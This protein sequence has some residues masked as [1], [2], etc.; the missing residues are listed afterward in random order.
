[1]SLG[2]TRRDASAIDE[3]RGEH[4]RTHSLRGLRA[5]LHT[6]LRLRSKVDHDAQVLERRRACLG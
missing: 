1:M 6:L 5:A 3:A 4:G 2:G